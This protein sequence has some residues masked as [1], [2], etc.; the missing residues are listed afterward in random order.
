MSSD[1]KLTRSGEDRMI[2]GVVG[3]LGEYFSIDPTLLRI[4]YIILTLL[5]GVGFGIILYV[6]LWIIMPE[7]Q[8]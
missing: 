5:T 6:V 2:A 7:D 3:G 4:L 8:F 1:K